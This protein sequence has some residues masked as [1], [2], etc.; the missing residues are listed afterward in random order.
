MEKEE[1]TAKEAIDFVKAGRPIAEPNPAFKKQ[2]RELQY[3][4][5]IQDKSNQPPKPV[6]APPRHPQQKTAAPRS[7]PLGQ[8]RYATRSGLV[9]IGQI[10][11]VRGGGITI[12]A[13]GRAFTGIQSWL[14]DGEFEPHEG[15]VPGEYV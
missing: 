11:R 3:D 9:K 4:L 5:G 15:Y 8:V 2:L 10:E 6:K 13:R 7:P 12:S 14:D 1:M